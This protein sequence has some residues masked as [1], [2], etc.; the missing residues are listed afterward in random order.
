MTCRFSDA[1]KTNAATRPTIGDSADGLNCSTVAFSPNSLHYF[2]SSIEGTSGIDAHKIAA[3]A[4]QIIKL[5][6]IAARVRELTFSG[7]YFAE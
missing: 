2:A 1:F 6:V 4:D 7:D 3:T 5:S